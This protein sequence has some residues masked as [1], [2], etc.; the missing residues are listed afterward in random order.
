MILKN[1]T[2]RLITINVDKETKY[3]LKPGNNP[4]VDVPDSVCNGDFV[5]ALLADRSLLKVGDSPVTIQGDPSKPDLPKRLQSVEDESVYAE[6]DK[7]QLVALCEDRDIEVKS[8]DTAVQLIE[9][10]EAADAAA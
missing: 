7:A 8:R 9:K 10:L 3:D 4:A 2:A 6:L 1:E 5:K